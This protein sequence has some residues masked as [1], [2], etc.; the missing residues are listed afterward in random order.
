[1]PEKRPAEE[2]AASASATSTAL[3]VVPEAKRTRHEL[4]EATDPKQTQLM[5]AVSA[6]QISKRFL[7]ISRGGQTGHCYW[8]LKWSL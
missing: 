5:Q 1:M 6:A 7:H 3:A 8:F 2:D 4:V